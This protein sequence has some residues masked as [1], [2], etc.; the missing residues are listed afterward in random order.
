MSSSDVLKQDSGVSW[1]EPTPINGT[2]CARPR[3]LK[4]AEGPL[5]LSGGRLCVEDTKDLSLW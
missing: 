4:L 2:G 3:L 1:S 5:L